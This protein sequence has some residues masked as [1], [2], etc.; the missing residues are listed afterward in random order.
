MVVAV[1]QQQASEPTPL[2]VPLHLL[3]LVMLLVVLRAGGAQLILLLVVVLVHL[4]LAVPAMILHSGLTSLGLLQALCRADDVLVH[5][6]WH[7]CT[8][9][10]VAR[11]CMTVVRNIPHSLVVAVVVWLGLV[12]P[13][14]RRVL[15]DS[16]I[17]RREL[18]FCP[19]ADRRKGGRQGGT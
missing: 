11:R 5:K 7:A 8:L 9:R 18:A 12:M 3:V 1:V 13:C 10:H 6:T 15:G 2:V 4:R 16:N 14:Q 19:A 17:F